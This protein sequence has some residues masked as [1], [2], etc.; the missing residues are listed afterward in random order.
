[1]QCPEDHW[2]KLIKTANFVLP[3][4]EALF[5]D[6]PAKEDCPICFLLPTKPGGVLACFSL[7]DAT[8]LSIPIYDFADEHEELARMDMEEYYSCCGKSIYKGC[9][10]SSLSA[11]FAIPTHVAKQTRGCGRH[12]EAG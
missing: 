2:A 12:K 9:S 4:H 1:L 10:L 5:K 3:S 8:I 11:P 7:P 6:P